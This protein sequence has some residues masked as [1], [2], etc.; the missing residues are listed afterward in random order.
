MSMQEWDLIENT[1]MIALGYA[2][3]I[4]MMSGKRKD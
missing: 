4:F 2:F 3:L 1:V